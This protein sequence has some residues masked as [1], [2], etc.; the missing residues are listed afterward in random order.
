MENTER[1][2]AIARWL[3]HEDDELEYAPDGM[4]DQ[5]RRGST[6]VPSLTGDIF[7]PPNSI[8]M[9]PFSDGRQRLETTV[10]GPSP[11]CFSVGDPVEYDGEEWQVIE[12]THYTGT[13]DY[14]YKLER[15]LA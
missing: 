3:Q 14:T 8:E 10:I 13:H 5:D 15:W 12:M 6:N 11:A 9:F 2:G 4:E 1:L 7:C